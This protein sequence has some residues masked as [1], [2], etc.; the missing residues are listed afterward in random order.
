ML[1]ET[2]FTLA[3]IAVL[4]LLWLDSTTSTQS[5]LV[6]PVFVLSAAGSVV[7]IPAIFMLHVL[8]TLMIPEAITAMLVALTG[9]LSLCV[10]ASILVALDKKREVVKHNR[11]V[12][13][14]VFK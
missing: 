6:T 13:L 5:L 12:R 10:P 11:L 8:P 14:T 9:L 1:F 3:S 7:I 4:S 2:T